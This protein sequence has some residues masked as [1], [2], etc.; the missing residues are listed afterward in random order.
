MTEI[1]IGVIGVG[2]MGECHARHVADLA[3]AELAWIA[4]PDEPSGR[5]LA[6][7]LDCRW[8]AE[9]MDAI[10]ECEAVVIACPDRF[11]HRYAMASL[12][13]GLPVLAEKPLTVELADAREI[14]DAEVA[15]GRR[16]IQLGFM[17][18]YDERH[19][20]VA[21]VL[22]RIGAPRHIRTV[23]RNTN[24]GSRPVAQMLV[25]S[26]I[27]D[28]HTVR[29]LSGQEIVSVATSVVAGAGGARV[30]MIIATCRLADGGVAVLEFDDIASGYEVSVEV[31][32]EHGNVVAAEPLRASV[33]S[34]GSVAEEIGDDWF[35]PFLDTYR[36]EMRDF[37]ES[38]EDGVARG[39]SAWDGYAAQA[40][41]DAAAASAAECGKQT[42]VNLPAKPSLYQGVH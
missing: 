3:G 4:D 32:A 21:A 9:G 13:R 20:Q 25:E 35:T 33:R 17:R 8:V 5:T 22:Q 14:V 40:V 29:W 19:A 26:I 18:V 23:H 36:V 41:V 7:E 28:I 42:A 6:G 1:R 34:G 10:D 39:P 12:E 31:T 30:R 2:G 11:H 38:V 15:L 24:D 27:H 37:L 16:L